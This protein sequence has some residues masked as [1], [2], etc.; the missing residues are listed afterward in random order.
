MEKLKAKNRS[1]REVALR[2]WSRQIHQSGLLQGIRARMRT[3]VHSESRT[4]LAPQPAN[5]FSDYRVAVYT[6]IIGNYD[7]LNTP[8]CRPNNIDYFV[9]T[10]RQKLSGL[11]DAEQSRWYKMHPHLLFPDHEYSVYLD[12][13][14]APVSDLT[15]FIHRIGPRGI[16]THQHYY[17]NCAY[18]EAQA[19]L[20]RGKDIKERLDRHVRFLQEEG[21][22]PNYGLADCGVIARRHHNPFC[23]SLM[24][25]WWREFLT[26]SRR[27]QISF[28]YLL[29]K[30]GVKIVEVATLGANRMHNDALYISKHA[31]QPN[32]LGVLQ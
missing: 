27:D 14:I 11:T 12:G 30:N 29:F 1:C 10:D 15:E 7:R 16:A 22:P 21:L 18:Q 32:H 19:V 3:A 26:H 2:E 25:Q 4:P 17:R 24:E 13:N 5:Y 31:I 6:S 20:E 9:I 28:P 23:V 8:G